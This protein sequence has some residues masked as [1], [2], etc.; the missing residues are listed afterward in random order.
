MSDVNEIRALKASFRGALETAAT[1]AAVQGQVDGLDD[2]ADI[3]PALLEEL[4]RVTAAHAVA[5]AALRGLVN[6]IQVRRGA[7]ASA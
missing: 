7:S 2:Q 5:S 6:T 3:D 4:A 1:L